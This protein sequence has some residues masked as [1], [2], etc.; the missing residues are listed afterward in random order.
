MESSRG[1][2]KWFQQHLEKAANIAPQLAAHAIRESAKFTV[3]ADLCGSY[4][5]IS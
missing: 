2:E 4:R 3:D 5:D 1:F